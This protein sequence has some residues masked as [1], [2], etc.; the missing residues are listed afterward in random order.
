M[1]FVVVTGMVYPND[2]TKKSRPA[3]VLGMVNGRVAVAPCSTNVERTGEVKVG[4]V[5][6]TNKSPAFK[7][8]NFRAEQVTIRV[9]DAGLYSIDSDFVKNC[10]QIGFLDTDLDKR[11][12]ENLRDM[13]RQYDLSQCARRYN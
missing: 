13:M 10:T 4:H 9:R 5:L 3:V 8:T 7:D 11:L 2:P 12:G 1:K 6:I